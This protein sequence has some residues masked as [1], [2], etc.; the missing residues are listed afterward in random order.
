M[1]G[2]DLLTPRRALQAGWGLATTGR[3]FAPVALLVLAYERGGAGA[4]AATSAALSLIGAVVA[5]VIGRFGDQHHLGR[6]LRVV[7]GAAAAALALSTLTAVLDWPSLVPLGFGTL[8]CGLLSMYRPLQASTLPW[9]VHTPRELAAANV[10]AAAIES[11]AS[12]VG[13]ALAAAVLLVTT[14]D[15]A[16]SIACACVA[17]AL[18][19]LARVELPPAYHARPPVPA[20]SRSYAAGLGLLARLVR[21]GGFPVLVGAQTFARGVLSVLL[22]VLVFGRLG[23]SDDAVGWLWAA[24]G[25]GGLAGAALGAAVLRV[26]R[27]LRS[28][29][30]GVVVWGVGLIVVAIADSPWLAG[31]GMLVIGIGNALEDASVFTSVARLAPRGTAAQA[32]S[33]IEVVVCVGMALGAVAAPSLTRVTEVQ[34]ALLGVG[35]VVLAVALV[36]LG[37]FTRVDRASH[38]AS[39]DTEVLTGVAIFDPLPLVVVEHLA[40][41]LERRAFEP[42]QAIMVEGEPGDSLHIVTSGTA[43]VTVAGSPRPDLGPGETFGE[44]ALL[45]N[46]PRTAT[47][48]AGGELTTYSLAR[49]EFLTAIQGSSGSAEALAASRL[50]RDATS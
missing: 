20:T 2:G 16:L 30:G 42:G 27:L 17:L 45:R 31:L 49:D 38:R 34:V 37:L 15:R 7:V 4:V 3:L 48:T 50:E 19:P 33:G 39:A 29:A 44:I 35:G 36:Y 40:T 46:G 21:A 26:S 11:I 24:M 14:P 32:M 9:L 1:L 12:M 18:V 43:L 47:V 8:A 28:F 22:V 10:G 23:M 5:T 6:V 41:R 25:V 13:P